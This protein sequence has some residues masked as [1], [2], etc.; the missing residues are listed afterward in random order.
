MAATA[1]A[2]LKYG[3]ISVDDH[4]QEPPDLWTSRLFGWGDRAPHVERGA[5][6]SEHWLVD[7][8]ELLNGHVALAGAAMPDRNLEPR[9]WAD[10][11]A[12]AYLPAE[13]LKAMDAAGVDYS[14]LYPTVGGLAGEAFGRLTDPDLELACAQAYNDWLIDEW[15]AA[16]DRFI[17]LCIVPLAPIEATVA[18]IRRAVGRGHRG[19]VLPGIPMHLREL[20][21]ISDEDWDP[22]WDVCEE[23]GVPLSLHAGSSPRIQYPVLPGLAP[24]L[25]DALNDVTR[26]AS[27]VYVSTNFLIS[28][29][30]LR[31]PRLQVV[32]AESALG[33]G[34]L[35]LEW[36]DHQFEHDG[37]AR[38]GYQRGP[39]E[40]FHSQCYF[41]G[42]YDEVAINAPYVGMDRIL[43]CTHYP[44]ANSTWPRTRDVVARC[45]KGVSAE[46]RDRVLWGNAAALYRI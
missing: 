22:V 12:S 32:L 40:I 4:V 41:T 21:H 17:P 35:H 36:A 6:G 13:R 3:L 2:K 11:P 43:W 1:P 29:I 42:W 14:V 38:E 23:L 33:W 30:L 9:T 7:G 28:R 25:A 15:A 5:D 34:T 27:S 8:Q 37:L 44:L 45:F 39:S 16:S 31:H 26:A 18:E 20:P 24:A 19:V 46:D 10:V